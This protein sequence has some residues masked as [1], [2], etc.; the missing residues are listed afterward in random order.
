MALLI[1][2][3]PRFDRTNVIRFPINCIKDI[4]EK[5]REREFRRRKREMDM[6]RERERMGEGGI[7]R[8]RGEQLKFESKQFSYHII[9]LIFSSIPISNLSLPP[10]LYTST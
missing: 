6:N 8:E 1:A 10:S 9:H 3:F 7:D 2:G 4:E 5:K